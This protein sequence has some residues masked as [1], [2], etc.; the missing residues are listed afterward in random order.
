MYVSLGLQPKPHA[1]VGACSSLCAHAV[2]VFN[3]LCDTFV[4][5][6]VKLLEAWRAAEKAEGTGR[7]K[8]RGLKVRACA[9]AHGSIGIML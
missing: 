4:R 2:Y 6:R 3:L 7:G 8:S 9:A 5:F 1:R